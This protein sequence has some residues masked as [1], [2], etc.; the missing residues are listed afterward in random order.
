MAIFDFFRKRDNSNEAT[1]QPAAPATDNQLQADDVLLKALMRGDPI[2]REQAM[3]IPAVSAAVDYISNTI[4]SMPI[5]LYRYVESTGTVKS[6]DDDTR[7]RLLNGDTG[8]TMDAYQMKKAAIEDY[9]M[10]SGGYIYIRR[11]LNEV[12]GL[13][14]VSDCYVA[15]QIIN[16][17][18]L[19]KDYALFVYDQQFELFDF[20]KILRNTTTG[21]YGVG[22][23]E[24]VA[25]ALQTAY[26][27]LVYQLNSVQNG[28]SKKG[29]LKS[30]R[31]LG[32]DEIDTLKRA[33]RNLYSANNTENVV[34]LNNGLEFQEASSSSVEMQLNQNKQT[35][36]DEI[37]SIF[38]IYYDDKNAERSYYRTFKEAIYPIIRAFET[39]LNRD[40]LLERE[41][42]NYYFEFDVKEILR[43]NIR[44]RY[45]AYKLAKET[46][47]MTI[48]EIR[49]AENMERVEGMDVINV[50]LAS[51]L[52]DVNSH[53]YYT[54]NVDKVTDPNDGH[55][56][57]SDNP[58]EATQKEDQHLLEED[59]NHEEYTQEEE[60]GNVE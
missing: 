49:R 34:V 17:N 10:G 44:E 31:K 28:G 43:V 16:P 56:G 48:N 53:K 2:T 4:A 36:T 39:A 23:T 7:V 52:Y 27:T 29:F 9:L 30:Q 19:H 18:P 32:Q 20:I 13:I 54:P 40:L 37:K 46:G 22:L 14:H 42:K 12:T 55:T 59:I 50:G 58:D 8:D 11:H 38:H 3:T 45:E 21:A 57:T 33:W 51:V 5:K 41:K 6:M 1:P 35:L 15:P 60:E 25:K 26:A 24:E 47:F